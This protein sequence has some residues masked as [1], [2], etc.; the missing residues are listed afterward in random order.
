MP[1][2]TDAFLEKRGL[3][4]ISERTI[5]DVVIVDVAG[6]IMLGDGDVILKDKV[7]SL[8]QQGRRKVI[9]NLGDVSY[10]DS[11]GLG[12]IVLAY[13]TLTRNN[14]A[15]KLLNATKRLKDLLSIAKL[16]TIF[17]TFDSEAAAVT[18]FS[19]ASVHRT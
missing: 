12:E 10:L 14:G 6:K 2:Y 5:G 11:A 18:S 1:D 15:L 17:E 8:V 3:M 19:S 9:L 16:L 7:R 13:A 4:Q